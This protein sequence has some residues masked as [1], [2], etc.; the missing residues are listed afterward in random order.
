MRE[1]LHKILDLI[2]DL[3]ENGN[4]SF[5]YLY[6]HTQDLTVDVTDGK[7]E[8]GGSHLLYK[9]E[10]YAGRHYNEKTFDEL[11]KKLEEL[12]GETK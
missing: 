2:L 5:M 1:K 6:G 7:W 8:N 10:Y 3:N 9:H 12:K 11:I 4:D